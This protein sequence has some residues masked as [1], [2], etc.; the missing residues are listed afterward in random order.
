M[1]SIKLKGSCFKSYVPDN[2]LYDAKII[3]EALH[4]SFLTTLYIELT[5]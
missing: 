3:N 4:V 2:Y 1:T 5:D